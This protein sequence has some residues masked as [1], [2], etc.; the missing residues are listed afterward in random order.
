MQVMSRACGHDDLSK[1]NKED[2]ATWDR[3]MA[4]LSGVSYSG[5]TDIQNT[6]S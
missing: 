3:D 4:Y 1:F 2:L 5:F 6:R